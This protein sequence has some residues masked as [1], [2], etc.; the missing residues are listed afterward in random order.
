M[1]FSGFPAC[2]TVPRM[3]DTGSISSSK[4]NIFSISDNKLDQYICSFLHT[5]RQSAGVPIS[6][7]HLRHCGERVG[8][9]WCL[10]LE[11]IFILC[12][13]LKC[14][15]L[16]WLQTDIDWICLQIFSYSSSLIVTDSSFSHVSLGPCKGQRMQNA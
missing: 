9:K 11:D 13:I 3:R 4:S 12:I 14:F 6:V 16:V 2:C 1:P 5:K 15:A 10:Q 8:S 7:L